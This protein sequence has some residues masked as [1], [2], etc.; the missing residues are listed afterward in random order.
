MCCTMIHENW[1][2][3]CMQPCCL[4]HPATCNLSQ[5]LLS[6]ISPTLGQMATENHMHSHDLDQLSFAHSGCCTGFDAHALGQWCNMMQPGI[7]ISL[8][9]QR[10]LRRYLIGMI[11]QVMCKKD[12]HFSGTLSWCNWRP[13][14]VPS[15]LFTLH[16]VPHHDC[17]SSLL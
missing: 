6:T 17:C 8:F 13:Y 15:C 1:V 12:W 9:Q 2:L 7:H 16:V 11:T 14:C 4:T 5:P 10:Y 3:S